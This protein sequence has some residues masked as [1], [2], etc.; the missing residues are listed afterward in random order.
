MNQERLDIDDFL[1]LGPEGRVQLFMSKVEIGQ[2]IK[3]AVAQ[4]AAE[5]LA[6]GLDRIDVV[7]ADT[8]VAADGSYTAGSNSIETVGGAVRRAAAAARQYLV[9]QAGRHWQVEPAG[10]RTVD[11]TVHGPD[12][13]RVSYWDLMQAEP[14]P[15]GLPV[16]PRDPAA[17]TVVG[18]SVERVDLVEKVT[19]RAVFVQDLERPDMLHGRVVRPPG[20]GARLEDIDLE[21]VRALP[22][23]VEIVRDGSFL[24]VVAQREEQAVS[25]AA[26][27]A[28]TA[29]WAPP[30]P[31][32]DS[33]EISAQLRASPSRALL[34]VDGVAGEGEVPPKPTLAGAPTL[35][36]QYSRPYIMHA[37]LGPSAALA[38]WR[39]GRLEVWSH[40][41]GVF[42][43][44]ASLAQVLEVKPDWVRVRHLEG[45]GCYG[46]NGADDAALDAALL[47][48]CVEGRPL[49]L[50]W[51]RADEHG[52]EPYGSAMVVDMQAGLDEHGQVADWHHEVKSYTHSGRPRSMEGHSNLLAAAHLAAPWAPAPP[53]PGGG[54]HG[55]IHR[56]ADPLYDFP[57]RRIV[58]HFV[59]DSPLRV[60]A[61]RGL[62]AGGNIFAIESFIDELALVAQCDGLEFRLR[63]LA[64]ERARAVLRA[65]AAKAGWPQKS[66]PG[67]GLGL[68]FA[69]YKNAKCYAAVAA[70]V[71]V[72]RSSGQIEL[73]QLFIAAD[74]GQ[75]VNPDGL[76]NQLEGGA[77]QA[78]SWALK[79]EVRCGP[80]GIRS[81]DWDSYPVLGFAEAPRVETVLI[82]RPGEPSR[83]CGEAVQGPTPAA[84]ANAVYA[85]CGARLRAMPFTP[86][87][88]LEALEN[89]A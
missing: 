80:K 15:P 54:S 4:I 3:L 48:R 26:T 2:G 32:P 44:R 34:V 82:D 36:A 31:L 74:A 88:L 7:R 70:Q 84:I 83:G 72:D 29:R 33:A 73:E 62:G 59:A 56:N 12:G 8:G 78:A 10:L 13:Q 86:Q 22:G 20:Y 9:Q 41:Q 1:R 27:L 21:P 24:G 39:Q 69:Q 23:V 64:D 11:G 19:G 58:K 6:V 14:F 53:R 28:A 16:Q 65:A 71:R 79:E 52:W 38:H 30:K 5:E 61:L 75:I 85:A 87:R 49:L 89:P 66:E 47:A 46:H 67:R 63:H 60:S 50:K 18:Q 40:T 76:A 68:A 81:L 77:V 35:A 57:R 17:Y 42:P 43:L 55:G 51:S 25:A 45:A 37:S